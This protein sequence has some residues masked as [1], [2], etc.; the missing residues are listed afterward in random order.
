MGLEETEDEGRWAAARINIQPQRRRVKSKPLNM[1][2]CPWRRYNNLLA[3]LTHI[4]V[5][6]AV[7]ALLIRNSKRSPR[8]KYCASHL[9]YETSRLILAPTAPSGISFP[10]KPPSTTP[11]ERTFENP[12][13]ETHQSLPDHSHRPS[14]RHPMLPEPGCKLCDRIGSSGFTKIHI[15]LPV[16]PDCKC[17]QRVA[18]SIGKSLVG[19]LPMLRSQ[20][21]KNIS[22]HTGDLR[23]IPF[24]TRTSARVQI[25]F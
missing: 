21:A 17:E 11:T 8:S 13:D 5:I 23:R 12:I 3:S 16:E 14:Q 24:A 15:L 7:S 19:L 18:L 20:R 6:H 10:R 4:A 1:T 22:V 2:Q 9:T 25:G